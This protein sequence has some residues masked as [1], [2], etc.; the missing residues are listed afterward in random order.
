MF[1]PLK[2]MFP[3]ADVPV[4]EMSLDRG[5]DPAYHLAVG[6]ALAPLR[7]ENVLIIAAGMSFHNMGGYGDPRFTA[8]AAAFDEWLTESVGLPGAARAARLEGLP[9]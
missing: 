4:V 8:G 1:V 6:Q 7:R 9:R 3:D 5:L 2:V